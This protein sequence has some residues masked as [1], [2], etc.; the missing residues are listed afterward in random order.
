[1]FDNI[2]V[3]TFFFLILKGDQPIELLAWF[4]FKKSV[5]FFQQRE[6]SSKSGQNTNIQYF[7]STVGASDSLHPLYTGNPFLSVYL[8]ILSNPPV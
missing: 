3:N 4:T 2:T 7:F 1:M 6:A 8:C 5:L